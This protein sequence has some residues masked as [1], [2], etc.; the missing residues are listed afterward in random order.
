MF[1]GYRCTGCKSRE[2]DAV[3]RCLDCANF[4]CP[5]CVMAHQFMHCFE[6]HRVLNVANLKDQ[7]NSVTGMCF[8]CHIRI[9]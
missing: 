4:L 2:S 7:D 3:A 6:G 1:A 8:A 5:N 9:S